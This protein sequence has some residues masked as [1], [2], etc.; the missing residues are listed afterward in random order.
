MYGLSRRAA[1]DLRWCIYAP[2]SAD[3]LH[4][5]VEYKISDLSDG[6]HDR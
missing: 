6:I 3:R 1:F 2:H 4:D 5:D